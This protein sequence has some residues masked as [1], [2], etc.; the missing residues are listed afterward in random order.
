MELTI[1]VYNE[2]FKRIGESESTYRCCA[3]FNPRFS[4]EDASLRRATNRLQNRLRKFLDPQGRSWNHHELIRFSLD[5]ALEGKRLKLELELKNRRLK[6]AFFFVSF[7][8]MD[9]TIVFM[10]KLPGLWFQQDDETL[11]Q[12]ATQILQKYF[13]DLEKQGSNHRPEQFAI[14]GETWVSR[15]ELNIRSDP[16]T[17]EE[18]QS[19]LLALFGNEEMDGATE[20]NRVGRCLDQL[21]PEDLQ[22]ALLRDDQVEELL[23][24]LENPNRRPVLI[25]G[26]HLV[27]KT[28]LVH[29]AVFRR[30]DKRSKKNSS[31][32]NVWWL[33]PQRLITGMSYVGQWENRL[34]A[35]L[36]EAEKRNHVLYFDDIIGIFRAGQSRDSNLCVADLIKNALQ[37]KQFRLLAETTPSQ[38]HALQTR[39]RGFADMFHVIRIQPTSANETMNLAIRSMSQLELQNRTVFDH[40]VLP[41]AI[42]LQHNYARSAAFPGKLIKFLHTLAIKHRNERRVNH[43]DTIRQFQATS[44]LAYNLLDEGSVLHYDEVKRQMQSLIIGQ[45]DAIET[46]ANVVSIAKSRLNELDKPLATLLFVG[47]TGVGKTECAKALCEV[48]FSSPDR[49]IRID[50]NQ[51]KSPYSA[52]TLVGTQSNPEGLLTS[53]V[54]QQPFSILLLDEIEK[55][56]PLVFDILLQVLGEGRLT[57]S[58]GRTTDFSNCV[59]IM[60]S[61]LGTRRSETQLGF[62]STDSEHRFIRAVRDFFRPEFFN[63]IDEIVPFSRLEQDEIAIIASRLIRKVVSR[64]GLIQRQCLLKVEKSALDQVVEIGFH[65]TL[66]ARA[67]KR[68]LE[69]QFTI[70]VSKTLANL[71]VDEPKIVRVYSDDEQLKVSLVALEQAKPIRSSE[72][73]RSTEATIQMVNHFLA[74]NANDVLASRPEGEITSGGLTPELLWYFAVD[75]QHKRLEEMVKAFQQRLDA[76]KQNKTIPEQVTLPR[77]KPRR[78][79]GMIQSAF[80]QRNLAKEILA[81]KDID[82]YLKEIQKTPSGHPHD[83]LIQQITDESALLNAMTSNSGS[84]DVNI[85]LRAY[86]VSEREEVRGRNVFNHM[87]LS[88][89]KMFQDDFGFDLSCLT[90]DR[91]EVSFDPLVINVRGPCIDI[92]AETVAGSYL[93]VSS[94]GNYFMFQ[95][96]LLSTDQASSNFDNLFKNLETE[97][98]LDSAANG[99]FQ[100]RPIVRII[101][102]QRKTIDLRSGYTF[103]GLMSADEWRAALMRSLPLPPELE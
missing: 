18:V 59:V 24:S 73:N 7:E 20:L 32:A 69:D 21:Y 54:R 34:L 27:G 1:P 28:N 88:L 95:I 66:G 8:L 75:E 57:D 12:R 77:R 33:S 41:T 98:V 5:P 84:N 99:P 19:Q 101:H 79:M 22:R 64:Q 90:P 67:M 9:R 44:G 60:T 74:R 16:R 81:T 68:A 61:N 93:F 15:M 31:K 94:S 76:A 43:A 102:G 25:V 13:R 92:L 45:E 37:A 62:A 58:L 2:T 39:D 6:A 97:N 70:P 82:A 38:F 23:E 71:P 65:P 4:A 29:E 100:I 53:A 46:C 103:N 35:I 87:G 85:F 14:R 72:W 80:S 63:R 50:L 36:R 96:G 30:V 11:E 52:S 78:A 86:H 17:E 10:P 51:F 3:L 47:P 55:A 48:L 26:E 42:R 83:D 91:S 56:H 49:L 89:S 40:Q